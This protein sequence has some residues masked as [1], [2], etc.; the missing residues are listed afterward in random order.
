MA[1]APGVHLDRGSQCHRGRQAVRDDMANG[2]A[3][4]AWVYGAEVAQQPQNVRR[5]DVPSEHWREVTSIPRPMDDNARQSRL[6]PAFRQ[7]HVDGILV[8]SGDP[9]EMG[10]RT[11]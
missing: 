4:G 6:A 9:P 11:M 2:G 10:R 1:A 3:D 8:G 5:A 7:H